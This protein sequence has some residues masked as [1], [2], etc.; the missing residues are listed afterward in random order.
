M[1]QFPENFYL[2]F[3]HKCFSIRMNF[4]SVSLDITHS[5]PRFK[6]LTNFAF[7][8]FDD[9]IACSIE[10]ACCDSNES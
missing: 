5:P 7:G 4:F 2:Q 8:V 6:A 10:R 1:C 3:E 9:C